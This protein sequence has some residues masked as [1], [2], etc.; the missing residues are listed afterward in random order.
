ME[1]LRKTL[2]WIGGHRLVSALTIV[3]FIGVL[4][5]L[6]FVKSRSEGQLSAPLQKGSIV[7]SV[8]GIGTVTAN[9]IWRIMP[10]VVNTI[11]D[12]W[13]LEGDDVKKGQKLVGN[14]ADVWRA[15]FAGT[16]T[17]LPYK[18]GENVFAQVPIL[19]LVDLTDRYMVVSMEQQA[20]LRVKKGQMVKMSF[21]TIRSER[22]DGTVTAVYSNDINYLARI[23]VASLPKNILPGMTADVA[24]EIRE[25]KDV[26]LAPVAAIEQGN[27]VWRK[28][29]GEIPTKVEIKTGIIDKDLAEVVS[30]DLQAGDRVLIRKDLTK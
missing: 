14:D 28:R 17:S 15:P 25:Q 27:R 20:A 6:N 5:F 29:G 10:G 30:G 1:I 13:V 11:S 4:S 24:I 3:V 18:V 9:K 26:L 2:K 22:F 19:T 8:Y 12:L 16:I 21:D 23:D 7:E